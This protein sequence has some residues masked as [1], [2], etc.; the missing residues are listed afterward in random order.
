MADERWIP[1]VGQRWLS[2]G[3][4]PGIS[5]RDASQVDAW[6]RKSVA[7]GFDQGRQRAS[8]PTVERFRRYI[9]AMA[10]AVA[11]R[12]AAPDDISPLDLRSDAGAFFGS[13]AHRFAWSDCPLEFS[14]RLAGLNAEQ[15]GS[16]LPDRLEEAQLEAVISEWS[17]LLGEYDSVSFEQGFRSGVA[18]NPA[19][20]AREEARRLLGRLIAQGQVVA[21]YSGDF[22]PVM[23]EAVADKKGRARVRLPDTRIAFLPVSCPVLRSSAGPRKGREVKREDRAKEAFRRLHLSHPGCRVTSPE[24]IQA[25][26][27]AGFTGHESKRIWDDCPEEWK[28]VGKPPKEAQRLPAD[29]LAMALADLT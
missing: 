25:L 26:R 7:A 11:S 15:L 3:W 14:A 9:A 13:Q 4:D 24:V 22:G 5:W 21:F 20:I 6:R 12:I 18:F 23:V 10:E 8:A 2:S 29:A 19:D 1:D 16:L 17:V 27:D 28:R